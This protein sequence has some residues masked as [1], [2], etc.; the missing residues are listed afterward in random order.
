MKVICSPEFTKIYRKL[1]KELILEIR[2]KGQR[3]KE[4]EG[5]F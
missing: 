1:Y 3:K 2:K 5:K 4:S